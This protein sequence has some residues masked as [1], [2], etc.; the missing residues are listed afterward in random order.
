[1][2]E[3]LEYE[4]PEQLKKLKDEVPIAQQEY[5]LIKATRKIDSLICTWKESLYLPVRFDYNLPFEILL[6]TALEA[7]T[8]ICKTF[9]LPV[10]GD[11]LSNAIKNGITA[12]SEK[13]ASVSFETSIVKRYQEIGLDDM[14]A[15][16]LLKPFLD[17][18]GST[19]VYKIR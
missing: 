13:T 14:Q 9:D 8:S 18:D 15:F 17:G 2:H 11:L 4:R 5:H 19:K 10:G 1:M 6:A 12:Q 3:F 16:R 7:C